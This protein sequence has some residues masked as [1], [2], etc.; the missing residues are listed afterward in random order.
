M[1]PFGPPD[2]WNANSLQTPWS[3][4][5]KLVEFNHG[6]P[7]RSG[8]VVANMEASLGVPTATSVRGVPAKLLIDNRIV[9]NNHLARARPTVE[10]KE[11]AWA[12]A[13]ESDELSNAILG[14][15]VGG[16]N[17]PDQR[18]LLRPFVDKYVA[19]LS[20]RRSRV[21]IP[22]ESLDTRPSGG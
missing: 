16:F 19:A 5:R 15:T 2:L 1:R 18:D 20:R 4:E 12:A 22:L 7:S 6:D 11:A 8:R 14:A 13:V 3:L 17:Q 9:I 10:A 21:R